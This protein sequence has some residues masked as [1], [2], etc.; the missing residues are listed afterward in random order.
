M[1]LV[2]AIV[3]AGIILYYLRTVV[4]ALNSAGRCYTAF[5]LV[6]SVTDVCIAILERYSGACRRCRSTA[7]LPTN[8]GE[9]PRTVASAI[10][11]QL[12]VDDPTVAHGI[13]SAGKG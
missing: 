4:V 9:I 7:E 10:P 1:H 8:E 3:L 2:A 6:L 5:A 13:L 11:S 12:T